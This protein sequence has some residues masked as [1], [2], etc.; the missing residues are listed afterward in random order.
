M[1]FIF[2]YIY[3]YIERERERDMSRARGPTPPPPPPPPWYGPHVRGWAGHPQDGTPT[4]RRGGRGPKPPGSGEGG[5]T[6][7]KPTWGVGGETLTGGGAGA[8]G[9][10][11]IIYIYIYGFVSFCCSGVC[12][13]VS[14]R[15]TA[16]IGRFGAHIGVPWWAHSAH[17]AHTADVIELVGPIWTPRALMGPME[18]IMGPNFT[19][20]MAG[21]T[22][23]SLAVYNCS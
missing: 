3:I 16:A 17:G 9:A 22:H 7:P 21:T 4:H 6:P 19:T 13:S 2:I 10:P 15:P 8:A 20:Q 14:A 5:P 12:S 23:S 1:L 18:S 11:D